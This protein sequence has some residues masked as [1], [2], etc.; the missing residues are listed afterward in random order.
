MPLAIR[1]TR[2]QLSWRML[3]ASV[4]AVSVVVTQRL[5]AVIWNRVTSRS[6]RARRQERLL[7]RGTDVG[8]RHGCRHRG[9]PPDRPP[10]GRGRVGKR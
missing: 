10:V 6:R 1:E 8:A 9:V 3:N 4:T 5:L 7:R 2:K